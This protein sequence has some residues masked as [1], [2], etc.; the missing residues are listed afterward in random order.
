MSA[1]PIGHP[2][3]VQCWF[4]ALRFHQWAKNALVFAPLA[5]AGIQAR[6]SDVA[7]A[8]FGFVALGFA[9]SAGY[10]FNDLCDRAADRLHPKKRFRP[11]ACGDLPVWAGLA[12]VPIGI[13]AAAA[14]AAVAALNARQPQ[15]LV[16]ALCAY[17]IGTL[18]YT[19]SFKHTPPFDLVALGGLF[20]IRVLAGMAFVP[21]PV[22][23]WLLT[24]AMFMFIGLAAIKRYAELLRLVR[25]TG[26]APARLDRGYDTDNLTFVM[27]L[28]VSC[29]IAAVLIFVMYLIL[30]RF[31][32]HIY[33]NPTSL[34]LMVPIILAWLMRMWLLA[35]RGEMDED[36][37]AFA[38]RD[39][40][41][42][43]LGAACAVFIF[44]AW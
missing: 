18:L 40:Q 13:V 34:W 20:T 8:G 5:L 17:L 33:G 26:N 39:P 31:P 35:S 32:A 27:A 3:V 23:L 36:P 1:P 4:R 30:D 2:S 28:G 42:W 12:A 38:L 29:G 7:A 19:V 41:S 44:F 14:F 25:E 21:P 22:S 24:F 9:S 15:L 37:I 11:F 6:P 10:I 43:T 16:E